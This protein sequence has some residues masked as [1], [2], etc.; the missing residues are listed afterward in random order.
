MKKKYTSYIWTEQFRPTTVKDVILPTTYKRT[1]N[2]FVKE[3]QVFLSM[4]W[5]DL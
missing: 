2:K 3:K 4:T 5:A 1:F